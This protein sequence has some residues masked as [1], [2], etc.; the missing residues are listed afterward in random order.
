[1]DQIFE[2]NFSAQGDALLASYDPYRD[3]SESSHELSVFVSLL[4]A[5]VISV[6]G[7]GID[8][9]RC[10]APTRGNC[11]TAWQRYERAS[12]TGS[13]VIISRKSMQAPG[14]IMADV[15]NEYIDGKTAF[16]TS[17]N[18]VI[19]Y[20]Q[21]EPYANRRESI[22]ADF[23]QKRRRREAKFERFVSIITGDDPKQAIYSGLGI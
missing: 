7:C 2:R 20:S 10:L 18:K 4:E 15:F 6:V 14:E 9:I 19:F 3:N 1:V 23:E 12:K 21:A 13:I 22:V 5:G 11:P 8:S 16:V 17:P